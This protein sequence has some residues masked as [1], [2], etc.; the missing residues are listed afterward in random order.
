MK[1]AIDFFFLSPDPPLTVKGRRG[2]LNSSSNNSPPRGPRLRLREETFRQE[3]LL[4]TE[5]SP[6]PPVMYGKAIL[7]GR[8]PSDRT[9]SRCRVPQLCPPVT[10]RLPS[11]AVLVLRIPDVRSRSHSGERKGCLPASPARTGWVSLFA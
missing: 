11:A 10:T 4:G 6:A 3:G 2:A 5:C 1:C 9:R 8:D 7:A